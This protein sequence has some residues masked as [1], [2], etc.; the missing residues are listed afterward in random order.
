MS[1]HMRSI[2]ATNGFSWSDLTYTQSPAKC[3]T[4]IH[5]HYIHSFCHKPIPDT[6]TPILHTLILPHTDT[7]HTL[8]LPYTHTAIY[9]YHIHSF[10]H[11]PIPP[12]THTTYTRS[13]IHPYH[14]HPY[15]IHSHTQS[16]AVLINTVLIIV[17]TS[18]CRTA[19]C[20]SPDIFQ[21]MEVR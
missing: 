18:S 11:T 1:V 21:W 13:A 6:H 15:H 3:K 12:Y 8:I 20:Q 17:G 10:C 2:L 9:P 5:P 14:R 4:A 7:R 16:E 19:H